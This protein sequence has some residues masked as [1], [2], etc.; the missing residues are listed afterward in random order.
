MLHVMNFSTDS[1]N[2]LIFTMK[3]RIHGWECIPQEFIVSFDSI[4]LA[5][6]TKQYNNINTHVFDVY[7]IFV[8][9]EIAKVLNVSVDRQLPIAT[10]C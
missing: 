1:D 7:T 9:C 5:I 3:G 4:F 6:L 8:C 10:T 2:R